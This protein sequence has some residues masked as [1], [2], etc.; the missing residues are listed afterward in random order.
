VVTGRIHPG[1]ANS[2]FIC[3]G[4]LEYICSDEPK[5][6]EFRQNFV[7]YVVPMI[8]PDGVVV[9]NYR[10]SLFGKDLNRTFNQSRKFAFPETF[11]L[12]E[13]IKDLKAKHKQRLNL[14]IDLHGH[15]VKKNVFMYGP[16]FN[17]QHPNY[18]L[19]K[20]LPKILSTLTPC[21]RFYSCIFRISSEKS[22]TARATL[23]RFLNIPF[24][25]TME[26]S[27]GFYYDSEAKKEFE[28]TSK[29]LKKIGVALCQAMLMFKEV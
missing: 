9:G 8:N 1:E 29:K 19:A 16:E 3:E 21:F 7:A 13:L 4:F 26:S 14:F 6:K 25:Y 22:T 24:T 15:S 27:N 5:A 23:N 2:S 12:L 11:H 18:Y 17:I 20:E 28:L 10:T